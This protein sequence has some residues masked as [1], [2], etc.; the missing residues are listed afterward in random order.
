MTEVKL[1]VPEENCGQE[2][3]TWRWVCASKRFGLCFMLLPLGAA[4][5]QDLSGDN[6]L[7]NCRGQEDAKHF[8]CRGL[9]GSGFG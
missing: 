4:R 1:G 9:A 2:F 3:N 8:R 6:L 7:Y 5:P